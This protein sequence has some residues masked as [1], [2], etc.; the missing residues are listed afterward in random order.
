MSDVK[1]GGKPWFPNLARMHCQN[2]DLAI[3]DDRRSL[4]TN[5]QGT[6]KC[7]AVARVVARTAA[8]RAKPLMFMKRRRLPRNSALPLSCSVMK[9]TRDII[10]HFV[11]RRKP[12]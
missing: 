3:P 10:N 6:L 8:N 11:T 9:Q 7:K 12:F 5:R 4:P 2:S 1:P